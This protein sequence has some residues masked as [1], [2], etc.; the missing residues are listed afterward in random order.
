MAAEYRCWHCGKSLA[1]L[2]LPF[3]RRDECPACTASVHV[4]RLCDFYDTSTSKDCR[5]PMADEVTDKEAANF[6]DYFR[7]KSGLQGGEDVEAA[8][9]RA[10]L[11]AVFGSGGGTSGAPTEEKDGG[12][13][14]KEASEARRKLEKL[15]GDGGE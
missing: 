12:E 2:I 7:P 5:E 10:R 13:D 6:C 8:Q 14:D 9:A 11:E 15:F 1:S 3:G 4:C